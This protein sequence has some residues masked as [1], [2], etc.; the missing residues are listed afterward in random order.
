ML[1]KWSMNVFKKIKHTAKL[2]ETEPI[3]RF[4][5][6][7]C[8]GEWTMMDKKGVEPIFKRSYV[9]CPHCSKKAKPEKW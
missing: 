5:C 2:I 4:T 7:K 6:I 8:T 9:T 1:N 3:W